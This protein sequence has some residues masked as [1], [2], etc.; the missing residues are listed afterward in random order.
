[1]GFYVLEK[2]LGHSL[3][4]KEKK[5]SSKDIRIIAL[6]AVPILVSFSLEGGMK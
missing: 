2:L 6:P 1:V 3:S 4:P 5:L